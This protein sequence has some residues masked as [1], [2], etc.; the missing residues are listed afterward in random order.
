MAP[1][2]P[3]SPFIGHAKDSLHSIDL[4][5]CEWVA[6]RTYWVLVVMDQ[7]TR[8]IIGFGIHAVIVDGRALW[9]MFN[10]AI[11]WQI[12]PKYLSSDCPRR[13]RDGVIRGERNV[14]E[15]PI[16]ATQQVRKAWKRRR[17]EDRSAATFNKLRV[18]LDQIRPRCRLHEHTKRNFGSFGDNCWLR[19][20]KSGTA[21]N[22]A[23]TLVLIGGVSCW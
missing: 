6:L 2:L 8:R 11:R 22:S 13:L 10:R 17:I 1:D 5:R 15:V 20:M 4:V 23:S 19:F 16:P 7:Y 14:D 9:R 21:F 3:G 18:I 12:L